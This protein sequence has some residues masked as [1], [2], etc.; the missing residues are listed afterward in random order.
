LKTVQFEKNGRFSIEHMKGYCRKEKVE[1]DGRP[2]R[3]AVTAF[4]GWLPERFHG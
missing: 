1:K 3:M 4:M 2:V